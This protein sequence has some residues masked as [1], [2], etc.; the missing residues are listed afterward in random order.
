[1]GEIGRTGDHGAILTSPEEAVTYIKA[2]QEN[3]VNPH[4][5]AIANGSTHGNI[6]DDL[7]RPIPQASINIEQT[8]AVVKAL[9][10]AK[11]GVRVAQHGITGTPRD[12]INTQF[13]KG[14]ILKGN[15]GTFWQNIL[16]DVLKD[17]TP[18]FF[19]RIEA[20]VEE[21]YRPKS[22]KKSKEELFG[23]NS[24][25]AIKVFYDEIY[26]L[27]PSVI[28]IMEAESYAQTLIWIKTF[29]TE[30]MASIV[31]KNI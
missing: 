5:L 15:V 2:L 6:Y 20:W 1:V 26:G 11:T 10:D 14:D 16:W 7:G 30:G 4:I 28:H 31:R 3:G 21:T 29:S 18:E 25:N 12:L 22:P 23:K 8:R 13:P 24:K 19:R 27:D 17:V 9:R